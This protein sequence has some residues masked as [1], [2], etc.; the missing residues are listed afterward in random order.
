MRVSKYSAIADTQFSENIT[1][2]EIVEIVRMIHFCKIGTIVKTLWEESSI[3][4]PL[5]ISH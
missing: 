5:N 4:V 2:K 1:N 3:F